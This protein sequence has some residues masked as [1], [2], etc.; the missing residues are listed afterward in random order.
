M[1]CSAYASGRQTLFRWGTEVL[2]K[3]LGSRTVLSGSI[4]RGK[5][6]P[7]QSLQMIE[8][9]LLTPDELKS[10]PKGEFVVMKTGTHPM[11]TRL[12]LFLDWGITFEEAYTVPK[13][14]N[15]TVKYASR[16]ELRKSILEKY[17][18]SIEDEEQ[19]TPADR[20]RKRSEPSGQVAGFQRSSVGGV[21]V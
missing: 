19:T 6:N 7:S 13:R 20:R 11:R 3:A 21:K 10:I 16:V 15:C 12:R 18:R 1:S 17:P 2:S 14:N 8:R 5:N 9:P 4:S